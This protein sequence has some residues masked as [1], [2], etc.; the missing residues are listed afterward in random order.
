MENSAANSQSLRFYGDEFVFNTRSGLCF[1]ITPTAAFILRSLIAGTREEQLIELIQS[2][3]EV[4]RKTA[5]R[6][7]ELLLNNLTEL[8]LTDH[9]PLS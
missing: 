2:R 6:D 9:E 5:V 8:G 3:Y 4:D 1:R 7:T